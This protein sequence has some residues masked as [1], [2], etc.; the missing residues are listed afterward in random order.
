[1]HQCLANLDEEVLG[2]QVGGWWELARP[3]ADFIKAVGGETGPDVKA[4][5]SNSEANNNSCSSSSKNI[6]EAR[7]GPGRGWA[8]GVGYGGDGTQVCEK[9]TFEIVFVY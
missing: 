3:C 9:A 2:G 4:A 1:M 7:G 6:L 5:N 8:K